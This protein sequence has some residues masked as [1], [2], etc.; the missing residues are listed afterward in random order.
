MLK[1]AENGAN[2]LLIKDG[3]SK[4]SKVKQSLDLTQFICI[5]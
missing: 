4:L 3:R 5:E 1:A 2:F